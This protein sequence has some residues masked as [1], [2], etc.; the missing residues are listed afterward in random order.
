MNPELAAMATGKWVGLFNDDAVIQ[1]QGWDDQLAAETQ[2]CIYQPEIYRLNDCEYRHASRTG[3]PFFPNKCWD[4]L[5]GGKFIPYPA[6]YAVCD[7]ADA[8]RWPIK[9][10]RGITIWHDRIA[11]ATLHH[12]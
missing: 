10:L 6:D 5:C 9:F 1:G 7:L 8:H 12:A 4:F 2:N 3:F 11:D